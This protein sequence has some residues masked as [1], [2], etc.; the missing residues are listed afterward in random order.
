MVDDLLEVTRISQGKIRLKKELTDICQ[1][2]FNIAEDYRLQ[3]ELKGVDLS[4][5]IPDAALKVMADP[6]RLSQCISNL[7]NNALKYTQP[8]G[9]VHLS[10]EHVENEAVITVADTGRGIYPADLP[11]LFTVF[12]QAENTG[13]ASSRGLGLGL[14]IAKGITELHGGSIIACSE[15]VGKGSVFTV[16]IPASAYGESARNM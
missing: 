10:L 16:R 14:A 3:Y 6:L 11:N 1:L 8:G 12:A 7:L 4:I 15:G 9:T 5:H 2:T 13:E